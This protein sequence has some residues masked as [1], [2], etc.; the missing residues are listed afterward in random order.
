MQ[1]GKPVEIVLYGRKNCH[2]CEQVEQSI[3]LLE[4]EFP[5]RLTVVDIEEDDA[6]HEK[7]M[8]VIPVVEIDGQEAFRS[9]TSVVSWEELRA[10]LVRRLQ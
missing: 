6:L 4:M 3:R 5:L 10:E 1:A 8:L 2:L 7:Y 9:V